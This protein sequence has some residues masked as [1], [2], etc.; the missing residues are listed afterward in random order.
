MIFWKASDL[1]NITQKE[2]LSMAAVVPLKRYISKCEEI[3][4][5]GNIAEA[6]ELQLPS[7]NRP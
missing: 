7:P 2:D 3:L 6:E 4:N 1:T 5:R